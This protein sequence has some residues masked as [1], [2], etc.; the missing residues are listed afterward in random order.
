MVVINHYGGGSLYFPRENFPKPHML[1]PVTFF[2]E[3]RRQGQI[4]DPD[5]P[6]HFDFIFK[7]IRY[8]VRHNKLQISPWGFLTLF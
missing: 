5:S 6:W 7:L 1:P 8:W 2:G 4:L 3:F